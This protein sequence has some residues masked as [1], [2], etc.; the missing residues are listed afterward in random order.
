M[1]EDKIRSQSITGEKNNIE[2]SNHKIIAE[3]AV[4]SQHL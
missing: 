4:I 1:N 2:V 3:D